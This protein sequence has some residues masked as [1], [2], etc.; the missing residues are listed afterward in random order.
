MDNNYPVSIVK[1][2]LQTPTAAD[3]FE[4]RRHFF[5]ENCVAEWFCGVFENNDER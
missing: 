1:K 5:K 2:P 4:G 3:F